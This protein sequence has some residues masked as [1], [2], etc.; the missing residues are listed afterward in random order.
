[1][2]YLQLRGYVF[3]GAKSTAP[4]LLAGFGRG[5]IGPSQPIAAQD[6]DAPAT[7]A[8]I[9]IIAAGGYLCIL[10]TLPTTE[11]PAM[12]RLAPSAISLPSQLGFTWLVLQ[13]CGAGLL[14]TAISRHRVG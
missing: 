12:G 4:Q 1:M 2:H 6:N 7:A 10:A 13:R 14:R 3:D 11:L 8:R 9:S 5:L